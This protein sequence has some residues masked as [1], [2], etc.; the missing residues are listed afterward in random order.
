MTD[1]LIADD[2]RLM[3]FGLEALLRD[4][5]FNIL[6]V[7]SDGEAVLSALDCVEPDIL[8]MDVQMPKLSGIDVLHR[9]Q[10]RA[11]APPVVLLTAGISDAE[12]SAAISLGAQGILLKQGAEAV[13]I[14]CLRTIGRGESWLPSGL[15]AKVALCTVCVEQ[16]VL[17]PLS[18]LTGRE[19]AVAQLVSK[20]LRN[21]E[22]ADR[23]NI[24]EGT[25]KVYL[26]RIYEKLQISNRTE[27]SIRVQ[28][29][30][31]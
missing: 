13:L 10:R 2:H 20:G 16:D 7:V 24:T 18:T 8:L 22:V 27:L 15:R 19:L 21:V 11:K 14:E 1:I 12:L 4:T 26:H 5:E 17:A 23:L 28:Q 9:L 25:V 31:F 3:L 30:N 29:V 6:R